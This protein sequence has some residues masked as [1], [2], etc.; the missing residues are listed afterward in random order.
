M[1]PPDEPSIGRSGVNNDSSHGGE[2]ESGVDQAEAVASAQS[3]WASHLDHLEKAFGSNWVGRALDAL[4]RVPEGLS[5]VEWVQSLED[6]EEAPD[7]ETL[8]RLVDQTAPLI[9]L[10]PETGRARVEFEG[11]AEALASRGI[12]KEGD[13][14]S[15]ALERKLATILERDPDP[16]RRAEAIHL[17]LHVGDVEGLLNL[18]S[19]LEV[20]NAATDQ[21]HHWPILLNAWNGLEAVHQRDAAATASRLVNAWRQT[22][23]P[24]S[25][26]A[27]ARGLHDLAHL[28]HRQGRLE[29]GE[30]YYRHALQARE[31][32]HGPAHPCIAQNL[33][34][35]AGLLLA[36]N[37]Y[38]EA[39]ACYRKAIEVADLVL[40]TEH[41]NTLQTRVNL[42]VMFRDLGDAAQAAPVFA[43]ILE[44]RRRLLGPDQ[45]EVALAHHNLGVMLRDLGQ[46]EAAF[47]HLQDGLTLRQAAWDQGESIHPLSLAASHHELGTTYNALGRPDRAETHL[48]HALNLRRDHLGTEH[49]KPAETLNELSLALHELGRIDEAEALAREA[50][51]IRE[52]LLDPQDPELATSLNNLAEL[53]RVQNKL[54]E[55]EPLYRRALAIDEFTYGAHSPHAAVG[56]NNLGLLL[57]TLNRLDEAEIN[58]RQAWLDS[59][60]SLGDDHLQ[61]ATCADHLAEAL[62]L[63]QR[64]AEAADLL[65]QA[66]QTR[67]RQLGDAHELTKQTRES[68]DQIEAELQAASDSLASASAQALTSASDSDEPNSAPSLPEPASADSVDSLATPSTSSNDRIHPIPPDNHDVASP[69]P[70]PASSETAT[71]PSCLASSQ[72]HDPVATAPFWDTP[73]TDSSQVSQSVENAAPADSTSVVSQTQTTPVEAVG[74]EPSPVKGDDSTCPATFAVANPID[75]TAPAIDVEPRTE[76]L[77]ESVE[78]L[79][80]ASSE[81]TTASEMIVETMI[82]ERGS[83]SPTVADAEPTLETRDRSNLPAPESSQVQTSESETVEEP[84]ASLGADV[85][86]EE[87]EWVAGPEDQPPPIAPD[88]SLGSTSACDP[89]DS[90]AQDVVDESDSVDS[91]I[92]PDSQSPSPDDL[93]E[94]LEPRAKANDPNEIPAPVEDDLEATANLMERTF[95]EATNS[96]DSDHIEPEIPPTSD[97]VDAS[98]ETK[99]VEQPDSTPPSPAVSTAVESNPVTMEPESET[100][101]PE[102]VEAELIAEG[103]GWMEQAARAMARGDSAGAERNCRTA[104]DVFESRLGIR[105]P[106]TID[107]RHQLITLIFQRGGLDELEPL[108]RQALETAQEVEGADHPN[109]I[110]HLKNLAGLEAKRG[111]IAS[112]RDLFAQAMELE[113]ALFGANDPRVAQTRAILEAL[114]ASDP[115]STAPPSRGKRG[116]FGSRR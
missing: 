41:P 100:G 108:L 26:E 115:S 89:L 8:E 33:N 69:S 60:D 9:G 49:L 99:R 112:A 107:V 111:R 70:H 56:L 87:P 93:E 64:P 98:E 90:N 104:L 35:L 75:S 21:P 80:E 42:A 59:R 102:A 46:L 30:L 52:R 65:R 81:R 1:T 58:L 18:L 73:A 10:H 47:N 24:P 96:H 36:Q 53:L 29:Q 63:L 62:R 103:R 28:F 22:V 19:D 12:P 7:A 43:E 61:T 32:I 84:T 51:V 97:H 2:F 71:E 105:H 67:R 68:L 109:V 110:V 17:R 45:P 88:A 34:N 92:G 16:V 82:V 106:A 5:P 76:P 23:P 86:S 25:S 94:A 91:M 13:R 39:E 37:R 38:P 78:T 79:A 95:R 101:M 14:E 57:I 83:E 113:R 50:L 27:I 116:W 6:L 74:D 44:A 55:A 114:S 31:M 20:F 3:E 11:L 72:T 15:L 85:A 48:R 40:G 54:D 77:D 4:V 66:L